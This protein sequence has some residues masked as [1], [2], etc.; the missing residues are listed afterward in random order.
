MKVSIPFILL[1]ISGLL[2]S[3]DE[4]TVER[5]PYLTEISF[6]YPINLNLPQYDNLR[7]SGGTQYIAQG[8]IRGLMI[9]NLNDQF[10]AWEASCPNHI[11]NSCSTMEIVGVLSQCNC[12]DYEYSLA[13]GQILTEN[14]S[15]TKLYTLL[16]YRTRKNGNTIIISN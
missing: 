16:N 2:L 6:E 8:G 12:E 7:F 13:T 14:S 1:L 10:L 15:D 5:N 4:S 9:F 3:C 11:P